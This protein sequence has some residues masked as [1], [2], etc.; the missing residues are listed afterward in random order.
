MR[1]PDR[2]TV[3]TCIVCGAM[4]R[5]GNCDTGC[6]EQ[7]LVLVRA[8][9]LES[10]AGTETII[11]A[12]VATLRRPVAEL[13]E[14]PSTGQQWP[15]AYT[16]LQEHARAALHDAPDE[17]AI[18]AVLEEPAEPAITWWCERCDGVD[19]PQPCLGVC[20]WRTVEWASHD[21]YERNRARILSERDTEQR[22]R[23]VLRRLAHT[24]PHPGQHQRSWYAF[25]EEAANALIPWP[26]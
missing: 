14:E 13:L 23:G 22:L 25:A 16:H 19:A 17:P 8:A 9:T 10:L 21:I 18:A 6:G 20:V 4:S 15:T 24:T 26:S 7:K 2:I 11:R 5:P 1:P 12:N 3:P